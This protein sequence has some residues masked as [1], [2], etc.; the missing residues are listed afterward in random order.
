M[1]N[2]FLFAALL[3]C[4]LLTVAS[5]KVENVPADTAWDDLID[6]Y[7]QYVEM[8][9]YKMH[10]LDIG[11]GEP[12]IFV[13]GFADS[14]YCWHENIPYLMGKG[15][16]LIVVDQPGLGRS[17]MPPDDFPLTVENLGEQIVKLADK[18]ELQRFSVVGSSMGGGI[19]LYLCLEHPERVVRTVPIDPA[20]FPM[21]MH[22]TLGL[23]DLVGDLGMSAMGKWSVR[24]ALRQVYYDNA[25]VD[26]VLVHEYSRPLSKP[27]YAQHLRRLLLEYPSP[28]GLS[29][30]DQYG[31]I[32]TPM[33]IFWGDQD[34]WVPPEFGPRLQ[35]M[36][37][38]ARL[39]VFNDAGHLPH[40]EQPDAANPILLDFLSR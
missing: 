16:R 9:E 6:P 12:V 27:G 5:C 39:V 31:R 36:I 1:R 24:I 20:C 37:P 30:V 40:Q 19:C 33:L 14:T 8:G 25:K 17:T 10:Y 7:H 35:A 2:S 29:M 23:I 11:E 21:E 28:Y 4:I 32:K 3:I 18:L 15:L 26:D 34:A 38:H 22:G 13:H